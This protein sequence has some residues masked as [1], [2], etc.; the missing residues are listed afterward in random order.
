MNL[1]QIYKQFPT[2]EACINHL[3]KVRW[4]N[5]PKCPYCKS[6]RNTPLKEKQKRY[7][8]NN[9]NT[10]FSVTVDTI[11]HN[12]K[13]DLQKWFLALTLI[14]NAKKGISSRQLA[15]DIETR[16]NTA[17]RMQMQVRKAMIEQG[18]LLEGIIE[19][20]ETFV[21]GKEKNKHKN[22]RTPNNQGRSNK[23]KQPVIGA[24]QRDGKVVARKAKGTDGRTLKSFLNTN[25]KKG[26][27]IMTDEWQAYR[28]LSKNFEHYVIKHNAGEYVNGDIYT[29]SIE[30]F[31]SL[32]KRGITGQYHWLSSKYLGKYIDE[33]CFRHNHRNNEKVFDLVLLKSVNLRSNYE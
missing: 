11:F 4:D 12:T 8:C 33:F 7:H 14:L 20:D 21:G 17:W 25:V 6:D 2:H 15:R 5:K 28:G 3:E 16:P 18:D 29:N 31:W 24:I 13:L 1:I 32:L 26:S 22:K 27:T 30:N 23:T 9:C 10:S 19:A